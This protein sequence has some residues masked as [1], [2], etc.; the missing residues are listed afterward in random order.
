MAK[1]AHHRY[2]GFSFLYLIVLSVFTG[3]K[4]SPADE[5]ASAPVPVPQSKITQRPSLARVILS[6]DSNTAKQQALS[7]VLTA[8]Q[9]MYAR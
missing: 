4:E 6:L 7:H 8:L 2:V 5:G 9:I 1:S 3:L